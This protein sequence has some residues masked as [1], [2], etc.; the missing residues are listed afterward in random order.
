MELLNLAPPDRAQARKVRTGQDLQA[1][2]LLDD[3]VKVPAAVPD[4]AKSPVDSR[5][6][7]SA[8]PENYDPLAPDDVFTAQPPAA[9]DGGTPNRAGAAS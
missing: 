7:A 5:A 9:R 2:S 3:V 8:I 4:P 1:G 6:H